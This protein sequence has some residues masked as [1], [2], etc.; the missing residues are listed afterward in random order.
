MSMSVAAETVEV[1]DSIEVPAKDGIV[2]GVVERIA[3]NQFH[4]GFEVKAGESKLVWGTDRQD[5]VNLV[6]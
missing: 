1:G 6:C 3:G 2:I 4:I 5:S